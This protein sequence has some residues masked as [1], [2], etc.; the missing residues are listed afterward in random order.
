[1]VVSLPIAMDAHL[2]QLLKLW[3]KR[4][5]R[6]F[7]SLWHSR[8][9]RGL[10]ST[11]NPSVLSQRSPTIFHLA[12]ERLNHFLWSFWNTGHPINWRL[13]SGRFPRSWIH[14]SSVRKLQPLLALPRTFSHCYD[15]IVLFVPSCFTQLRMIPLFRLI[16]NLSSTVAAEFSHPIMIWA[17]CRPAEESP[18]WALRT[19]SG[20]FFQRSF[21]NRE[22]NYLPSIPEVRDHLRLCLT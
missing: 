12:Q 11:S 3:T 8:T 5:H 10:A 7:S 4:H 13:Q 17:H 21:Q 6:P 20:S 19:K 9:F 14:L 15:S 16:G 2:P 22:W 18:L 1:M